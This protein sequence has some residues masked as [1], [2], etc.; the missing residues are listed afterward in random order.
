MLSRGVK[1]A[2]DYD[3]DN[4]MRGGFMIMIAAITAF[5]IFCAALI[6]LGRSMLRW[7]GDSDAERP[8]YSQLAAGAALGLGAWIAINWLLALAHQLTRL[9]IAI[10]ILIPLAALA[11]ECIRFRARA[12][13]TTARHDAPQEAG[14][15][16]PSSPS[17]RIQL[18]F[19]PFALL[20]ALPLIAWT[21]Y[22]LWR[23][24][25]LPPASH[26]ALAY[27]LP[28]A[29]LMMKAHGFEYFPAP[30][31]RISS[32]PVN[33]EL[34]VADVM[35]LTG[36]DDLTEWISTLSYGL[37]LLIAAALAARWWGS[38]KA[39]GITVVAI[40]ATPLLL[41]HSGAHKNDILTNAFA[42]GALL[43]GSEW[44]GRGSRR[45]FVLAVSCAVMAVGTK[46]TAAIVVLALAPFALM[47]LVR[48]IRTKS[49]RWR[50]VI[51]AIAFILTVSTLGG[52]GSYLT[53]M[54]H[55]AAAA[56]T[57]QSIRTATGIAHV[58]YGDWSNLWVV[59]VLLLLVPF[60]PRSTGVWVPWRHEYWFWPHYE[61]FFSHYGGLFSVFAI[62]LPICVFHY[63][64]CG[65]P[66]VA[67]ERNISSIAAVIAVIFTLPI[68]SRP[69]GM[70][71]SYPRYFL[72][73]IPFVLCWTLQPLLMEAATLPR[74]RAVTHFAP[75]VI[76]LLFVQQAI[77]CAIHDTF[78][79]WI[80]AVQ[81]ARHPGKRII[82][83]M[84]SR[85]ASVADRLAGPADTIAVDGSFDTW[86][87]PA[88]GAQL[89]RNVIFLPVNPKPS[90]IPPGANWVVI[91]RYYNIAWGSAAMTDFGR[92]WRSAGRGT[93]S[94]D[95]LRLYNALKQDPRFDLVYSFRPMNQSVFRRVTAR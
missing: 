86:V 27:H 92:F 55:H 16:D 47:T 21:G 1:R 58:S 79:P 4:A 95:D 56:S 31:E 67:R 64:K 90:D 24:A 80:Y 28:K 88:W 73:V 72:F 46:P 22:I 71:A 82:W 32:L 59:P 19:T 30:D 52:A 87:Y 9:S 68:A 44:C 8:R 42:L 48:L 94:D 41:L 91:D 66:A 12:R 70:F 33:Y 5:A 69:L 18:R 10:A 2:R 17:R 6:A 54:L 75:L 23:G 29:V 34:L 51:A 81:M 37:F 61:I 43:W 20:L 40:A 84:P 36:R 60:S 38:E 53:S 77:D 62:L 93:P 83:F 25:V 3:D 39:V 26:D 78:S 7:L 57:I 63:R 45:P 50:T 13:R 49:I 76:A 15:P 11:W 65:D 85:A 35:I 74:L 89:S 14:E